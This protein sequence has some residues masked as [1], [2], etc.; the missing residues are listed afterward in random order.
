M[1]R[2]KILL[3]TLAVLLVFQ[4]VVSTTTQTA[5]VS[6]AA[7]YPQPA[8]TSKEVTKLALFFMKQ[9]SRLWSNLAEYQA[10]ATI[11]AAKKHQLNHS[12]LAGLIAAESEGY[13]FAKSITGAKGSGQV[14]FVAHKDRFPQIE[15]E[16]DKYDPEKNIDCAAELL[17]EYVMKYGLRG[18]LQVYNLGEGSYSRGK[19]SEKYVA[20]VLKYSA[21]FKKF[22][23]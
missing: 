6:D 5:D 4:P 2:H 7:L 19:R 18:G 1:F 23:I 9:D 15:N 13:P 21:E 16:R 10:T 11:K 14:D 12:L 22:K 20:R 3:N 17:R 8:N